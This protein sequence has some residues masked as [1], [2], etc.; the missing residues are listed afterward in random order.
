VVS[1]RSFWINRPLVDL[2]V[3]CGGWSL[4]LLL[5]SYWLV[6]A[7]ARRW[8]AVFYALA[9]ACNY[10]HYM[11]TIH[12]AYF[13][14]TDRDRH[15]L[16]THYL[17]AGLVLLAVAAHV[18]PALL[19][20]LFTAYVMWSPWHYTGQ[21]FGLGMMF[22]RRAGV[23]VGEGERTRLRRAFVASYVMLLVAFNEAGTR[24]P[25]VLSLNLPTGI[26]WPIQVVFAVAFVA[27]L[28]PTLVSLVRR[29]GWRPMVAPL[30]LVATQ[31]LWFVVP[32]VLT[33]TGAVSL[34]QTRYSSGILAVMHSAQYLWITQH[35]ARRDAALAAGDG[36][37]WSGAR[38]W[39]TL[40][41]GGIALFVPGPWLASHLGHVD[42]T[43]SMLI[44]TSIVN[45][46]HFIVDGVV[47]KLR[48]TRVSSVLVQ[49]SPASAAVSAGP[50]PAAPAA[51]SAGRTWAIRLAQ[52]GAVVALVILA[53]ID[54]WRYRLSIPGADVA[55]LATARRLNPWD[56]PVNFLLATTGLRSGDAA[57][58][59]HELRTAV[60]APAAPRTA[61][62]ALERLLV[63]QRRFSE[64]YDLVRTSLTRWP[65][66][67][68]ALVNAGVL[69][70]RLDRRVDAE[71]CWRR[72]LQRD[73]R[74]RH[75]HLYLAELLDSG[76][77]SSEAVSHYQ[78]HLELL[79][80]ENP[81]VVRSSPRE[82][83][84]VAV[85]FGDALG[86]TGRHEQAG[87]QYA[88]ASL[89]ASR[90]GLSDVTE[91]LRARLLSVHPNQPA[92]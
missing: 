73:D 34:M 58:A 38:Y 77:R 78:R 59:E 20:W 91:L 86:R 37:S 19:P 51:R 5:A 82:V 61:F 92:P 11:A 16:V 75:V 66:D 83:A 72:A 6:D 2:L 25:L 36:A 50:V 28:V 90:A 71:Q 42:F 27:L 40:V 84:L 9:L 23:E 4:P 21:N 88:L 74:L 53:A 54:Q 33:W 10:P 69:A 29:A 41:A 13:R 49:E 85:K 63:E 17:T 45:L 65:D 80:A 56:N 1:S 32:I 76:N 87:S 48:D 57:L 39:M 81:D 18:R 67:V 68:D 24:D 43:T 15:R 31:T 52:A 14:Q 12:R 46:H 47:W 64:A 8:S 22:M 35:Y 26:A 79:L 60:A 44:V 3:G 62:A 30:T 55:S 7:D 89:I 70:L